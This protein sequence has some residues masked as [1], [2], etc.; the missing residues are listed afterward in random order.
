M[1]YINDL[2]INAEPLLSSMN[3]DELGIVPIPKSQIES[4][5]RRCT[6]ED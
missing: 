3:P 6:L 1:P 5:L 4:P 2:L